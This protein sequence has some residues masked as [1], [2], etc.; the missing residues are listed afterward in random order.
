[1]VAVLLSVI[2]PPRAT[3]AAHEST[4]ALVFVPVDGSPAP[5]ATGDGVIDFRGGAELESRWTVQLQLRGL[6]PDATYVAVLQGRFGE[7]ETPGAAAFTELCVVRTSP[8][9]DGGCWWYLVGMRR[10]DVVQLR[11]D[12]VDGLP[13]AQATRGGKGPGSITS[14]PNDFSPPASPAASPAVASPV[15]S[16]ASR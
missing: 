5:A 12:T 7:P 6:A 2:P 13:M 11:S 8:T 1:M 3:E 10:V 15:A 16:P 4:N 14:V 9:G